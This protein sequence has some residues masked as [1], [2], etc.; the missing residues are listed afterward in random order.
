MKPKKHEEVPEDSDCATPIANTKQNQ[1]LK[2]TTSI[3][4]KAGAKQ[5]APYVPVRQRTLSPPLIKEYDPNEDNAKTRAAKR[6]EELQKREQITEVDKTQYPEDPT[7]W[8]GKP[9]DF[10]ILHAPRKGTHKVLNNSQKEFILVYY[11]DTV[12]DQVSLME[13]LYRQAKQHEDRQNALEQEKSGMIMIGKKKKGM[14]SKMA[15]VASYIKEIK[16]INEEQ[17][18]IRRDNSKSKPVNFTSILEGKESTPQYQ[19]SQ[20][21]LADIL[22]DFST[23]NKFYDAALADEPQS[24]VLDESGTVTHQS[25]MNGIEALKAQHAM[26]NRE[27]SLHAQRIAA[28]NR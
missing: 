2:E 20:G 14:K 19:E 7:P 26:S 22:G 12:V 25:Q 4:I 5:A 6:R 17:K 23:S 21:G 10:F 13:F 16:H 18:Y 3:L 15:N 28:M 11:P 24:H 9:S 1:N 8:K 27:S